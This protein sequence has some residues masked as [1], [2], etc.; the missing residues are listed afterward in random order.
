MLENT[1]TLQYQLHDDI[2]LCDHY[3]TF[4]EW[5]IFTLSIPAIIIITINNAFLT[6]SFIIRYSG[7]DNAST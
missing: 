1:I 4:L 7:L 3:E 2:Y 6:S 5:S